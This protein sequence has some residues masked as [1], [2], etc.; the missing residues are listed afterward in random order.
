MKPPLALVLEDEYLIASDVAR[1]LSQAGFEVTVFPSDHSAESWLNDNRPDVA[2]L[3]IKLLDGREGRT[4]E[5]LKSREIPFVVVSGYDPTLQAPVFHGVPFLSKPAWPDEL[6][7]LVT[8]LVSGTS[9][10]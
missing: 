5:S 2:V 10:P 1:E 6:V 7:G 3:D 8:S 4:A 9:A